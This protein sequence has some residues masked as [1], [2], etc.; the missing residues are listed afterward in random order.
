MRNV[1]KLLPVVI[2]ILT[3]GCST[4][5][6]LRPTAAIGTYSTVNPACPGAQRVVEFAPKNQ[7]WVLLRVYAT[8]PEG[9]YKSNGTELR[10]HV[11]LKYWKGFELPAMGIFASDKTWNDRKKLIRERSELDYIVT[12]SSPFVTVYTPDGKSQQILVPIFQ[13]PHDPKNH[14][15]GWWDHGV[16]ISP[17]RLDDFKVI[18]P[19]I[20]VNGEKIEVPPIHFRMDNEYYAP[21][22]NC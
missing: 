6:F 16:Q 4:G 15:V 8:Q 7:Y 10:V 1:V 19:D 22:L 20:F 3:M 11:D 17:K 14:R 13:K 2:I 12:A 18:F 9:N 5:P 21:V